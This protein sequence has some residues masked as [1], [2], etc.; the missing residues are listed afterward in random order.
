MVGID[1][2]INLKIEQFSKKNQAHNR[3][4]SELH[5]HILRILI[6]TQG[7]RTT[8][9]QADRQQVSNQTLRQWTKRGYRVYHPA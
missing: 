6:P 2:K 5:N 3:Q 1:F 4:K 9:Q 8:Y 7:T